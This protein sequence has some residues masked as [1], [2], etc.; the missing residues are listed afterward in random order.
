MINPVIEGDTLEER[1]HEKDFN[2]QLDGG[3]RQ[4]LREEKISL[5]FTT[6]EGGKLV[7]IGPGISGQTSITERNFERCMSLFVEDGEQREQNIWIS[8]QHHMW[9]LENGIDI[10]DT[11]QQQWDRVYLPRMSFVTGGADIHEIVRSQGEL[12]GVITL[13]NCIARISPTE[14]GSFSPYW[15]PPFI[16]NIVAEDRCHLNGMCVDEDGEIAYA[17]IVGESNIESGWREHKSSGGMLMDI[18]SNEII[19]RGLSMPHTPRLYKGDLWFLN[20]GTGHVCKL[21]LKTGEVEKVLWRP[22]FLRGLRFYK[23]YAFVCSS[24]PRDK[25]FDG[26]PLQDE[27]DKRSEEAICGIDIIDL[28][29]MEVIHTLSITGFVK[30][31]YDVTILE[32]CLQPLLYGVQKDDIRKIVV[33][34]KD[35]T[36]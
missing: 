20:A 23:N 4:F 30:E 5:A 1:N 12:Y 6:Y 26:L 2:L 25:V 29:T 22:G 9:Q 31:I 7:I 10:G 18:R 15:K 3:F 17:S 8:T 32:Q 33:L 21:N 24:A 11:F 13:Y 35:E 28:K 19:A 36:S 27:L 14:K 34:G 16:D